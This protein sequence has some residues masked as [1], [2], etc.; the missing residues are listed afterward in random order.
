M[1]TDAQ[2]L[3][4][5]ATK[6]LSLRATKVGTG[7]LGRPPVG[8][9]AMS[10]TERSRRYRAGLATKSATKPATK[11]AGA[12]EPEERERRIKALKTENKNLKAKLFDA[13]Q[14]IA[15]CEIEMVKKGGMNLRTMNLIAKA[16]DPE[17]RKYRTRTEL[18]AILDAA[19]NAFFA[20][21]DREGPGWQW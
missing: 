9:V 10:S 3:Q 11:P 20:W 18:N 8:E 16:F 17:T 4:R 14:A 19:G 1:T 7:R 13:K 2:E 5:N 21:A 15:R 12:A 6:I